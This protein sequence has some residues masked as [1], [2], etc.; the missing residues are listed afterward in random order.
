M[1]Y[2]RFTKVNINHF[3]SQDKTISMRNRINLYT[4]RDD[5]LLD[6]KDSTAYKTYYDFDTGK[7]IPKIAR[8]FKKVA[9]P[10]RTLSPVLEPKPG[11]KTKRVK[12]LAKKSTTASIAGVKI[13]DTPDAQLKKVLQKS[14]QETHKV[15]ATGSSEGVGSQPKVPEEHEDKTAGTAEGTGTKPGVPNVPT[16]EFRSNNESKGDSQDDESND[17]D[18]DDDNDSDNKDDN[19][20]NDDDGDSNADDNERTDSDSDEEVNPNL[21]PKDDEEE[22]TQD[23]EYVRTPNYYVPTNEESREENR[24]FDEEEYDELYKDVNI[25]LKDIEL[26]KEGKGDAEMTDVGLKD[27]SQEKTYEQ[28]VDDAHM[29]LTSTQKTN[30]SKFSTQ[31]ALQSY[32]TVFEKKAQEEKDRYIAV[33][34]KSING[35]IKDEVKSQLPQDLPKEVSDFATPVIQST[36]TESLEMSSWLNLLLNHKLEKGKSYRAAKQHRDLYDALVKSYQLENDLFDSY[37][38]A[39]SLKR[40]LEDKDKDED[41]PARSDRGTKRRK[42]RKEAESSRY[43]MSKEKKSSSTSKGTSYSQNKSSGK[44]AH[45]EEPSHTVDDS[46]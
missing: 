31:T 42:S 32:T 21:N 5:N 45:A 1:P 36:I 9:S 26:K 7:V 19:S 37:G 40:G 16:Y 27:I 11:K 3:I 17:V 39:Y 28:V 18:S 6:I 14:K 35:I 38:K 8:K 12:R 25:T 44:S 15:H 2:P 22:E 33:I 10:S 46:E 43:S 30:G 20:K 4:V 24:E 34:E 23:D 29:T 13:R 41:P